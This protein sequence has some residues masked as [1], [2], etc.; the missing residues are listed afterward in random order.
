MSGFKIRGCTDLGDQFYTYMVARHYSKRETVIVETQFPEVF[1]PLKINVTRERIFDPKIFCSYV[2]FKNDHTTNQYQD[3]L[4][5]AQITEDLPFVY[6]FESVN[7]SASIMK[8]IVFAVN[9]G[10][11]KGTSPPLCLVADPYTASGIRNRETLRPDLKIFSQIV[12]L[13]NKKYFTVLVGKGE[14][15]IKNTDMVLKGATDVKELMALVKI[16]DMIFTQVGALLPMGECMG[17]K[18]I[19]ILSASYRKSGDTFLNTITPG[20]VV[21]SKTSLCFYDDA[22]LLLDRI[23]EKI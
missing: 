16:S 3:V 20:K 12:D 21:C 1:E 6:D 8:R 19:S 18:V 15:I 11:K 17:R 13:L 7:I 2:P 10:K 5:A 4:R 14:L 9:T 22:P 23:E